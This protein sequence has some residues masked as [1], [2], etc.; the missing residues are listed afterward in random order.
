MRG[1]FELRKLRLVGRNNKCWF[2]G[3]GWSEAEFT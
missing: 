3:V 2:K 1:P